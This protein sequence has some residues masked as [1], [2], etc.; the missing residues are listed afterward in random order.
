MRLTNPQTNKLEDDFS[1]KQIS[2]R[3]PDGA[4]LLSYAGAGRIGS[5]HISDWI[6]QLLRGDSY[7][8]DQTLIRIR[9]DATRDLGDRLLKRGIKHMFSVGAFL[10]GIPWVVQIRNFSVTRE[11]CEGPIEREFHTVA[12]KVRDGAGVVVPWPLVLS[13][14]DL[15]LLVKISRKRPRKPKEFS[16]LLGEVNRRTAQSPRSRGT[17]SEHCVTTYQPPSGDGLQT[18]VHNARIGMQ[19][20]I[21][22]DLLFGIDVT[23]L[24]RGLISKRSI[25]EKLV[26]DAVIPKNLL[27]RK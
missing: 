13:R 24:M 18:Y 6:R 19:P 26:K 14:E 4:A 15:A 10:R 23:E 27:K 9:Q 12:Q 25:T 16:D 21:P 8:L 20:I 17:V 7:T 1:I 2:F 22:P 5:V 11:L 3:C